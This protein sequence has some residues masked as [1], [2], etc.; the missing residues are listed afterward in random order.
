ML[1]A[2]SISMVG[3]TVSELTLLGLYDL[4]SRV[5]LLEP[6][7]YYSTVINCIFTFCPNILGCFCCVKVQFELIKHKFQIRLRYSFICAAFKSQTEWSNT[8]CQRTTTILLRLK[9]DP[10]SYPARAEGLVNSTTILHT[11]AHT[12]DC[13][14]CF[15]YVISVLQTS[16]Y[17]NT[18]NFDF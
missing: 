9:I 13:L 2:E 6:A 1:L 11:I 18:A 14:N 10:V 12:Y 3:S 8:T 5:E 16:S 7:G 17:Q 4:A 15:V